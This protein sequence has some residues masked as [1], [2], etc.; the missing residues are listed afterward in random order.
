MR[1]V[2]RERFHYDLAG[3]VFPDQIH[4]LLGLT[5]TGRILY[6]SDYPYM[7]EEAIWKLTEQL[8]KELLSVAGEVEA[9]RKV[10]HGNAQV[11]LER[12]GKEA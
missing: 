11:L 2:L 10:N 9:V 5:H 3:W 12:R 4:A 6:G 8:D 7:N 1:Q